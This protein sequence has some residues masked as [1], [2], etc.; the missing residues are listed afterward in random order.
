MGSNE[1]F[2]RAPK[3][4]RIIGMPMIFSSNIFILKYST[5]IIIH[6][7]KEILH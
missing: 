1:L 6:Y 4:N 2:D 7:T 3:T 5:Y